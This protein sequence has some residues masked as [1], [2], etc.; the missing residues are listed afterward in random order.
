MDNDLY[1]CD[2]HKN[3][4]CKKTECSY[5]GKGYCYQT[6]NKNFSKSYITNKDKLQSFDSVNGEIHYFVNITEEKIKELEKIKAEFEDK[7]LLNQTVAIQI[8][9]KHISELK[10]DDK[11]LN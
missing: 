9:D 7:I 11:S 5:L 4:E 10:G 3:T 1:I 8:M 2:P 6:T